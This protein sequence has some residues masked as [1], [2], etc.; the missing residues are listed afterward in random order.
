[1]SEGDLLALASGSQDVNDEFFV[2]L[3]RVKGIYGECQLLLGNEDQRLGT[4][5]ME[6]STK[7]LNLGYQKLSRWVQKELRNL[8]LENPQINSG[9]RRALRAL[10]ERPSLFQGCLDSFAEAREDVLTSAFQ[11][12]MSGSV[13]SHVQEQNMKPIELQAH[14]PLRFVGDVLAWTHSSTVSERE[15]LENLFVAEGAEFKKGLEAGREA[16]PWSADESEA[17][18]GQK[19]LGDLVNRDMAGVAK[20]LRQR[21]EQILQSQEDPVLLYKISNL[22]NFYH[23]TFTKLLGP[24]FSLLDTLT[25]LEGSAFDSFK[26][27]TQEHLNSYQDDVPALSPTLAIPEFLEEALTR[28]SLILQSYDASLTPPELRITNFEPVLAI[29]LDPYLNLCSTMAHQ[30]P[31]PPDPH[32]FELNC[33]SATLTLLERRSQQSGTGTSAKPNPPYDFIL[34]Q[35]TTLNASSDTHIAALTDYQHAFFLHT[36]GLHPLLAALAPLQDV[37][38]PDLLSSPFP[39]TLSPTALTAASRT[40]DDFLPSALMDAHEQIG[41]LSSRALAQEITAEAADRFVGDFEFVEEMFMRIDA[42]RVE[43]WK[44]VK[45]DGTEERE[46]DGDSGSNSDHGDGEEDGNKPTLM[47]VLFPRTSGEIRVLLS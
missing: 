30:I 17:F 18:D 26:S 27:L 47:R 25:A 46:G 24:G 3:Q 12:A 28:L 42:Q 33:L 43:A 34:P 40:L 20:A 16:E 35:L 22:I 13:N 5:L 21:I 39:A 4:E 14:D 23:V 32:I 6:Q 44:R 38:S 15:A 9:I 10:A 19:A 45:K 41:R 2:I 1:M 8:N 29:A 7:Y 37:A 31:D 36:S 11:A